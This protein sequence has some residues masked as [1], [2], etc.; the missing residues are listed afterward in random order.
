MFPL[1]PCPDLSEAIEFYEAMGFACSYRQAKPNPYA[2]VGL[3]DMAIHLAG[4]PGFDPQVSPCS[5]IVTVPDAEELRS[6]FALGLKASLGRVP[7]EGVPR[8]LRLRRKAGSAVG[9]SLVD[10]GGNWLRFY[11]HGTEEETPSTRRE[12]LLRVVDVAARQGEARGDDALALAKVDAGLEKYPSAEAADVVEA[13]TYRAELLVRIG[14][15]QDARGEL[16]LVN[17]IIKASGV[18]E[19]SA[20]T[21]LELHEATAVD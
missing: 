8:L 11:Q 20:E 19:Y 10:P 21:L 7:V 12:G 6:D 1:L 17:A 15:H 18:S 14:R 13:R 5:A 16:D 3:E 9:F 2:V 4:V